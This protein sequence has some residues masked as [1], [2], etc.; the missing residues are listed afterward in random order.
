VAVL[1]ECDHE[2][3]TEFQEGPLKKG[4]V[5]YFGLLFFLY[6]PGYNVDIIAGI[7]ARHL[8]HKAGGDKRVRTK[9]LWTWLSHYNSPYCSLPDLFLI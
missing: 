3:E 8:D 5:Y 9:S 2:T 4:T 1:Q 6:G 7:P